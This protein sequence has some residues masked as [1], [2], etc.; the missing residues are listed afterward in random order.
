MQTG[1]ILGVLGLVVIPVLGW[2]LI[3]RLNS[4]LGRP[5][6]RNMPP[7]REFGTRY[8][9]LLRRSAII[10]LPIVL[11]FAWVLALMAVVAAVV[12]GLA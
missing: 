6:E 1:L 2:Y 10:A 3:P 7:V 11:F 9:H 12:P 4:G 8:V 5:F